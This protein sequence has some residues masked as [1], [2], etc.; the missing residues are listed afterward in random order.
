MPTMQKMCDQGIQ[1]NAG[2]SMQVLVP[3]SV[4]ALTSAI[5]LSSSITSNLIL[6][7]GMKA[8]AVGVKSTKAGAINVQRYLDDAGLV[9]QGAALTAALIANTA[10]V[11]NVTDGNPFASFTV[12]ITNTDVSNPA[13][14]TNLAILLQG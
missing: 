5:P 14:L 13:A 9:P 2:G 3:A 8:V 4:H 11:L 7:D 1:T 6:S 12:N 10:G